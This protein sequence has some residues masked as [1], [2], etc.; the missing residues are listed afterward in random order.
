MVLNTEN[1]SVRLFSMDDA[2]FISTL[3][4]EPS[5]IEN[6]ADKGIRTLEDANFKF[7]THNIGHYKSG[8]TYFASTYTAVSG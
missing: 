5:F 6:I 8:G 1:L 4:N 7:G 2:E 3:L